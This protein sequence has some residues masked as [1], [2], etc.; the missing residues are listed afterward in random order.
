MLISRLIFLFLSLQLKISSVSGRLSRDLGRDSLLDDYEVRETDDDIP[1]G[2][3]DYEMP[4]A[5][6]YDGS[7]FD[8]RGNSVDVPFALQ[9]EYQRSY[10]ISQLLDEVKSYV[11]LE[12]VKN[13]FPHCNRRRILVDDLSDL[14][15]GMDIVMDSSAGSGVCFADD[16]NNE[17]ILVENTLQMYLDDDNVDDSVYNSIVDTLAI[18]ITDG[19]LSDSINGIEGVIYGVPQGEPNEERTNEDSEAAR[20]F[21][22]Q[23]LEKLGGEDIG[24]KA[25]TEDKG[26]TKRHAVLATGWTMLGLSLIVVG[27]AVRKWR[28]KRSS[29]PLSE[30]IVLDADIDGE[31]SDFIEVEFNSSK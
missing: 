16:T 12:M 8:T 4:C 23:I 22:E 2:D 31:R 13:I 26:D 5:L 29:T 21:E 10:D 25:I 17:C 7:Y 28:Q 6:G 14:T 3:T 30:R 9:I 24:S 27:V 11:L 19:G 1:V 18:S 20:E 15:L